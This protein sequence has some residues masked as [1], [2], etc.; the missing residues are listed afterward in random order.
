MQYNGHAQNQDCVSEILKICKATTGKYPIN[1]ITR[2]FNEALDRY[3]HLAFE[4][5]GDLGFDD[6]NQSSEPL[7]TLDIASGTNKYQISTLTSELLQCFQ[8][9][10]LDSGGIGLKGIPETIDQLPGSFTELYKTTI[11]GVPTFYLRYGGFLY[12][13]STPNYTKTGGIKFYFNRPAT[14]MLYSDTTK[15]PGIPTIHHMYLCRKT[16]LPYLIENSMSNK[17]DIAAQIL[18][19]EDQIAEFFDHRNKYTHLKMRP[20]VRRSR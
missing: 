7:Q 9:E 6:A 20:K 19:D 5:G 2:R 15:V 16:A 14:R 8:I 4:A 3:F 12:I 11:Q 17:N 1:D 10:F 13:R 18:Q